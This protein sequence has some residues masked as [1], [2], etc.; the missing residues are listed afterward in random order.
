MT[1]TGTGTGTGTEATP[2]HA[3]LIALREDTGWRGVLVRGASGSGKSTLAL[4]AL[5]AGGRLVADDRVIVWRSGGSVY[6]RAPAALSGLL[7]VRGVGVLGRADTLRFAAISLVLDLDA[8]AERLPDPQTLILEGI[9]VPRL[10][11]R[12]HDAS[13]LLRLRAALAAVQRRL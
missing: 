9:A 3:S 5:A 11:L 1:G 7:E 10:S 8:S 2:H 4:E 12:P 6:G 13:A